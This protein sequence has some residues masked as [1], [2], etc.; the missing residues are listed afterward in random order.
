MGQ[1]IQSRALILLPLILFIHSVCWGAAPPLRYWF[2]WEASTFDTSHGDY[3][4]VMQVARNI[5]APLV[6]IGMDG[7]PQ[8]MAAEDWRVDAPGTTWRFKLRK[9]LTFEDG[10]PVTP[11]VALANFRR[12]IWL[13]RGENLPLNSL[14]PETEAWA[15][16]DKPLKCLYV[17][18]GD[19]VF[20]FKRRPDDL[21]EMLSHPI[22][23]IAS[24]ECFDGK[25]R[26]KD[27]FC[28][29]AS[30]Q[31]RVAE[32][33]PGR[34]RLVSRH[35]FPAADKAPDSVEIL[36][37]LKDGESA[38]RAMLAG[39]GEIAIE[40][41]FALSSATLRIMA[42]NG[43]E[44]AEEPPSR[45][46][47]VQLNHKKPPFNDKALRR[48]VRDVFLNLFNDECLKYGLPPVEP[49]FMPRGGVGYS[50]F[51]IPKTTKP[52]VLSNAVADVIFFP[53]AN[54]SFPEDRLLQDIAERTF[55]KALEL[56]GLKVN[57]TRHLARKGAM[58]RFVA[59]DYNGIMRGSG[60]TI[61]APYAGLKMM[62]LSDISAL[63][64]DPSG[65]ASAYIRKANES[66]DPAER[67]TLVKKMNEA[68]FDDAAAITYS[69]SSWV[70][71]HKPGVDMSR[72]NLFMDP[73]EFRAISWKP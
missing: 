50:L 16:Y 61:N 54:Y 42:D 13:T 58:K 56:H 12:M 46:Y 41:R 2:W 27:A 60:I 44:L 59:G 23:G 1:I 70:Y 8:G 14:M 51:S 6:S 63:I 48:S 4:D 24:P 65:K 7:R 64:P 36:T 67:K 72:F 19:L 32:R 34:I 71:V 55:V 73:I 26:W 18:G 15:D 3:F 35:I 22:Y 31:Y 57:I 37:P 9:G 62:F 40:P 38:L 45:M 53:L 68:V 5:Y 69:H 52:R 25:G 49:S 20:K 66:G 43:L 29:V 10:L 39:E 30:G 11:E 33:L 17:D 28:S 21:F 47:F